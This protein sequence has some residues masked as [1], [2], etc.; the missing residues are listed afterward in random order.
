MFPQRQQPKRLVV[1]LGTNCL[2]EKRGNLC[3]PKAR[4]NF[5]EFNLV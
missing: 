2:I 5:V 3:Y 4:R 1:S